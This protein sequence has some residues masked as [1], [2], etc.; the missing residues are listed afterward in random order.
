MARARRIRATGIAGLCL[1][2][3]GHHGA[4]Q[5][6]GQDVPSTSSRDMCPRA[7]H[8]GTRV[9]SDA[10]LPAWLERSGGLLR[11]THTIAVGAEHTAV[12]HA[13]AK[14]FTAAGA[15]IEVLAGVLWHRL[16]RL[17]A[18]R[19]TGDNGLREDHRLGV[20][21]TV[22]RSEAWL[23]RS[24]PTSFLQRLLPSS[25][26]RAASGRVCR[27][28]LRCFAT[29]RSLCAT[30]ACSGSTVSDSSTRARSWWPV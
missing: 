22:S 4:R 15:A 1:S 21:R 3:V 10:A 2:R 29:P 27:S 28:G 30:G 25:A 18:A 13:W 26:A 11:R 20:G 16:A 17:R 24:A 19:R 14:Q 7:A 6:S 8:C 5:L 23:R 9:V 12:A